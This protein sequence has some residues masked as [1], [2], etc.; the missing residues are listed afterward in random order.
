M[1]FVLDVA[2]NGES[3]VVQEL[4]EGEGGGGTCCT[5]AGVEAGG[6]TL[7]CAGCSCDPG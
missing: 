3:R 4:T 7:A 5:T 6:T 1:T 2:V